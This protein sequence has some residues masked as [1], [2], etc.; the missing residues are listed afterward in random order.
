[1]NKNRKN[2]LQMSATF[3]VFTVATAKKYFMSRED[4][5][6]GWAILLAILNI[7]KQNNRYLV[8]GHTYQKKNSTGEFN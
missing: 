8:L 7:H 2:V 6:I 1:M 3:L 4:K 5:V